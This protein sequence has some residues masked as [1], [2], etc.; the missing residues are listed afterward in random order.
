VENV[1]VCVAGS[2]V[3]RGINTVL[4]PP[5]VSIATDAGSIAGAAT[6][7]GTSIPAS[8]AGAAGGL[9]AALVLDGGSTGVEHAAST[10][11]SIRPGAIEGRRWIMARCNVAVQRGQW[12]RD[13]RPHRADFGCD[14]VQ[15][16][17]ARAFE[18]HPTF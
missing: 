3:P 16:A 4:T 12:L 9:D 2:G 6:A 11:T 5:S 7:G 14:Q 1:S 8:R 15:P 18:G 10:R 13:A 17:A